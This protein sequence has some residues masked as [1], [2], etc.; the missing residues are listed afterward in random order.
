MRD[1][2]AFI[3]EYSTF[4]NT[5]A[6]LHPAVQRA[7]LCLEEIRSRLS[8][9]YREVE[10]DPSAIDKNV[11]LPIYEDMSD[12]LIE[13]GSILLTNQVV[14]EDLLGQ[15]LDV[16][17]VAPEA[18]PRADSAEKK[19]IEHELRASADAPNRNVKRKIED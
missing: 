8:K 14:V 1:R 15:F 10:K 2:G 7:A 17:K 13:A 5:I 18:E 11:A 4:R 12:L 9:L 6:A 3:G 19:Q 16:A